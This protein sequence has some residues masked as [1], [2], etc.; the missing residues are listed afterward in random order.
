MTQCR[1]YR[2]QRNQAGY[3]VRWIGD[4]LSGRRKVYVHR[5]VVAMIHG[6]DAIDGKV[7]RH[8]CD[9]P[10]CFL[11]DHLRIGT[12]A[13]NVADKMAKGRYY[14]GE[15]PWRRRQDFCANGGHPISERDGHRWCPTCNRLRSAERYQREKWK[16]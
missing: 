2:G 13:D 7:V 9:N 14:R 4:R 15:G 1:E 3:G 11:Y 6:W 10:A 16:R 12:H 8:I 5:W